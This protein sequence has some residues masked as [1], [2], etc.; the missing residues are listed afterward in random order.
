M[1]HILRS[2]AIRAMIKERQKTQV[3][4]A[5]LQRQ[6]NRAR[7]ELLSVTHNK[8]SRNLQENSRVGD[9]FMNQIE[10]M[11]AYVPYMTCPGN[12]EEAW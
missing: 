6:T 11:A 5:G 12:H 7:G 4:P 8:P 10:P 9:R 1:Q 3:S 2:V